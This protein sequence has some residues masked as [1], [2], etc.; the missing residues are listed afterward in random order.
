MSVLTRYPLLGRVQFK[1]ISI[2]VRP[3]SLGKLIDSSINFKKK[4]TTV[5]PIWTDEARY[6]YSMFIIGGSSRNLKMKL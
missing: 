5:S 1:N 2:D 3:Y 6:Q 4:K